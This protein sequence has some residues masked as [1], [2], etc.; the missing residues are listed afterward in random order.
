MAVKK[1]ITSTLPNKFVKHFFQL[2]STSPITATLTDLSRTAF[3]EEKIMSML[4]YK[5]V[6]TVRTETVWVSREDCDQNDELVIASHPDYVTNRTAYHTE[7]NITWTITY[8]DV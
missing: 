3:F 6:L 1:I 8:E 4:K 2:E 5:D 7:N